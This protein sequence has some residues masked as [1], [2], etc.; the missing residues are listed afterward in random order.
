[1]GRYL[2]LITISAT[3]SLAIP[4]TAAA[5]SHGKPGL[6]A[7]TNQIDFTK[8]GP[9]IPPDTIAKMRL[10]GMLLPFGE[11][12]TSEVCVSPQQAADD[13]PPTPP[14]RDASCHIRNISKNGLT[15]SGDVVCAGETKGRGHFE[16]TYVDDQ[17][18]DGTMT[19]DGISAQ[20]GEVA[21][22]DTFSGKW[23]SADCGATKPFAN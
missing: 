20:H 14:E 5:W 1:M 22:T 18:Y 8:G 2:L 12:M 21:T 15:F 10:L 17:R 13:Q 11:P 3:L 16:S 9:D 19:F 6:W 23:L 7:V 4:L